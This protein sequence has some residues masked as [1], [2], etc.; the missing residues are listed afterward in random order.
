MDSA[1]FGGSKFWTSSGFW[2]KKEVAR[3]AVQQVSSTSFVIMPP[4]LRD[5]VP[6]Q[7]ATETLPV[8]HSFPLPQCLPDSHPPLP[9]TF[10][11]PRPTG[12]PSISNNNPIPEVRAR[13]VCKSN[14]RS[15]VHVKEQ[16]RNLTYTVDEG[17]SSCCS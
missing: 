10:T 11:L 1:F 16:D 5:P 3:R 6:T 13:L 8:G 7:A 14:P 2:E 15:C 17:V 12:M 9:H 4:L